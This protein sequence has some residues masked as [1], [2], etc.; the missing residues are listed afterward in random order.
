MQLVL[1]HL[2]LQLWKKD[3]IK[4]THRHQSWRVGWSQP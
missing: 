1:I 3:N 2:E 4:C